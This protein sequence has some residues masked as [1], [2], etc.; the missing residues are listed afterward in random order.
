[1]RTLAIT[2]FLILS[3]CETPSLSPIQDAGAQTCGVSKQPE[4]TPTVTVTATPAPVALAKIKVTIL[5]RAI[6]VVPNPYNVV[7]QECS[8]P[9]FFEGE[10][11]QDLIEF[12][13]SCT[14][15][16]Q[17][18][19]VYTLDCRGPCYNSN[20]LDMHCPSV[21]RAERDRCEWSYY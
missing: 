9:R 8:V 6:L 14:W 2:L 5:F 21:P 16:T 20:P 12:Y 10:R 13:P 7:S 17:I 11:I 1:M 4:P 3:A 18:K 15:S 19:N